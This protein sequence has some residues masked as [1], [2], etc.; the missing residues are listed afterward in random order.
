[1]NLMGIRW[2]SK[3]HSLKSSIFDYKINSQDGMKNKKLFI[4]GVGKFA[5]YAGYVF[6]YDSEYEVVGS[7]IEQSYLNKSRELNKSIEIL[8]FENLDEVLKEENC[9]LFIA[10]GNNI[11][12]ERIF[13][14]AKELKYKMAS[15]ISSK[16]SVWENLEVGRNCFVDEGTTLQPFVKVKDNSILFVCNVGHHSVIE[17]HS[18]LSATILGGNV[19]IGACS[20][21]GMNTVIKQNVKIGE[22]NIMGMG[23][24]IEQDTEPGSV[25]SN[26]GTMKRN[27]T[28]D[29]L[30]SKFL[31]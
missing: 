29:K 7:C 22:K 20:Y 11:I 16:A 23:C 24:I 3:L 2:F 1:M 27:I 19:T 18:L 4:Y 9:H 28:Y 30:F 5:E 8:A 15:Y 26:K 25:Y 21:L 10:V 14:R 12:R 13:K 31:K 17:E 6:H